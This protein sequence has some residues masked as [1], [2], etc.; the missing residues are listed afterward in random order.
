MSC[1]CQS[2]GGQYKIDIS[3]P[4]KIWEKIKPQEK[5]V[6]AGLL[7]ARCIFQRIETIGEYNHFNLTE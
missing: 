2:C 5:E 3:V 6:G 4:N 1:K 7:C